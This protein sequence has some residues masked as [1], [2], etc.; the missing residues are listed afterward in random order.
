VQPSCAAREPFF[1]ALLKSQLIYNA[2]WED[3]AIDREA[4]E[5]SGS[6]RVLV[7]TSAG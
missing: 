7:I 6:D 4:L 2:C 3:P 1:D 5:F